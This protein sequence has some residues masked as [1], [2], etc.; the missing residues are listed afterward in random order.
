[1]IRYRYT[2]AL[3]PP[4][5]VV[6][7]SVVCPATGKRLETQPA[8]IDTGADCTVLPSD[9]DRPRPGGGWRLQ[10]RASRASSWNCPCS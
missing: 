6:N 10:L 7:V 5:P 2:T 8:Q 1:M 9:G 3:T 4:A